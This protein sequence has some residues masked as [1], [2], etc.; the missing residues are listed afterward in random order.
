MTNRPSPIL[1]S[2]PSKLDIRFIYSK[3]TFISWH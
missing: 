1:L 3:V 2:P